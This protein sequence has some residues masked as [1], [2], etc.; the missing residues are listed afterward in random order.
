MSK[1]NYR[2][3]LNIEKKKKFSGKIELKNFSIFLVW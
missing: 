2:A 1:G 3:K